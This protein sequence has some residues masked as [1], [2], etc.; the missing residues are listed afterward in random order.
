MGY[1]IAQTLFYS[2][3]NLVVE[4]IT[5]YVILKAMNKLLS[6]RKMQTLHSDIVIT[7]SG[8]TRNMM[9]LTSI[10][11]GNN[12]KLVV[13]M[14]SDQPGI[15]KEKQLKKQLLVNCLSVGSFIDKEE[16]EI[17]DL[18]SE[19]IY[20]KASKACISRANNRI[21]QRRKRNTTH[22]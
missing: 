11:L 6:R 7:P 18:F 15:Q 17:E 10:L 12:V 13:L 1:S 22:N 5:D 19:E 14:D 16:A 3:Y 9:P 21:Y 4:G 8:G 20:M 2:K